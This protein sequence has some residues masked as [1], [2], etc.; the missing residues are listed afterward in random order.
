MNSSSTVLIS[1]H[2]WSKIDSALYYDILF[3]RPR[4]NNNT[5]TKIVIIW[6]F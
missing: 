6:I 1:Q 5:V 4:Y 3:V 2:N